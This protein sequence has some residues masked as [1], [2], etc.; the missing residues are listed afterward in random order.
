VKYAN[1][2]VLQIFKE[3]VK[4]FG[5]EKMKKELEELN[6]TTNKLANFCIAGKNTNLLQYSMFAK[7]YLTNE[8]Y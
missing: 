1:V 8:V 7:T 4:K 6:Y 3:K 5:A 2:D